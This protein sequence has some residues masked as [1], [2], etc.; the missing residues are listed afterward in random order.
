MGDGFGYFAEFAELLLTSDS[1]VSHA[2][3]MCG[4]DSADDNV[5][6]TTKEA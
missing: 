3:E 2:I 1:P 6:I 4:V 5:R